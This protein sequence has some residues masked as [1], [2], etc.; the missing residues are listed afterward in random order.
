MPDL[1]DDANNSYFAV[2][3]RDTYPLSRDALHQKLHDA[4]IHARRYF[5]PLI[6]H[7]PMYCAMPSAAPANLPHANAT[8]N[9]VICLPI[10]P[11]LSAQD[12]ERIVGLIASS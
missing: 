12:V 1:S 4:G 3:V 2:L 8:A 10:Y 6:S 11:A 5:Y 9:Q 7:F